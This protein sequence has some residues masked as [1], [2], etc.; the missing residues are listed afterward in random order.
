MKN[1]TFFY[2]PKWFDNC[3]FGLNKTSEPKVLNLELP[4]VI[5][6]IRIFM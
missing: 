1:I 3:L 4:L 2:S 6:L 5:I